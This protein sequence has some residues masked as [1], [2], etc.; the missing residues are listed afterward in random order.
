MLTN[1]C[2]ALVLT[3]S[4][5]EKVAAL[6]RV[7]RPGASGFYLTVRFSAPVEIGGLKTADPLNEQNAGMVEEKADTIYQYIPD[8]GGF[9]VKANSKVSPALKPV[10]VTTQMAPICWRM[11]S[12]PTAVS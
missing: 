1:E 3:N 10:D 4:H 12:L 9:L 5:L 11:P 8:F 6:A 2:H 7:F